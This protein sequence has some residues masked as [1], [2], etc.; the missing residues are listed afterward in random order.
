MVC[1][2][3]VGRGPFGAKLKSKAA[4]FYWADCDA[5][6]VDLSH[7]ENNDRP[8]VSAATHADCVGSAQGHNTSYTIRSPKSR[9]EDGLHCEGNAAG[10]CPD[11]VCA[12]N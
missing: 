8:A 9:L 2:I 4:A 7:T 10:T 12:I 3:A 1:P 11:D 5:H 6:R